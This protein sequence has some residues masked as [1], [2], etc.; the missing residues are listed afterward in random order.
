MRIVCIVGA[1]PQFIKLAPLSQELKKSHE[2]IVVHTGQHYD[3]EMSQVFFDELAIPKPDYNLGIGSGT[4]AQQTG[5]MLEAIEDVLVKVH[6]DLTVVFGDTNSTLAGA[7]AAAKL[8]MRTAH[9]EAGLRSYDRSMPEE[10]NRVLTD[11]LSALLFAPTSRAVRN[12]RLEGIREGVHNLG[13]VMVDALE[14]AKPIARQKSRVLERLD[15]VEKSYVA[16]TMHRPANTDDPKNLRSILTAVGES[17]ETVVFPVHPR[18]RKAI[19][20]FGLATRLPENIKMIE[21]LGYLDMLR[22][23]MSAK[24][25]VTDSGGIQKEAFLLGTRCIT[26]RDTTEWPETLVSGMNVL[27]GADATHIVESLRGMPKGRSPRSMPFG[28][29]GA[30]VRIAALLNK[31][32]A[33]SKSGV[34]VPSSSAM[35]ADRKC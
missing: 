35:G 21:P 24:A 20:Q 22:L 1:R 34:D 11:H 3:Y 29:V 32:H 7:L 19:D 31:L 13:D 6:P 2:C 9:V 28:R 12:L 4:H 30:S 18:T 33:E 5:R 23:T 17:R 25:M 14:A 15:L 10:I 16:M 27:V 26:L 8:H